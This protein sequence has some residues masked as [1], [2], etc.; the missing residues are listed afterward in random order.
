[1]GGVVRRL[2]SRYCWFGRGQDRAPNGFKGP[3]QDCMPVIQLVRVTG[4]VIA[5]SLVVG[6]APSIAR[7]QRPA[8]GPSIDTLLATAGPGWT[9]GTSEHFRVYV[10]R[11]AFSSRY[12]IEMLDSLERAWTSA[13]DLIASPV[14]NASPVTVLVTASRTRFARLLPPTAKGVTTSLPAVGDLVVLVHN[15]SVRP[16]ARHEVMHVVARRAWG[17]GS[18]F[19]GWVN[20]GLATYADGHCQGSTIMAVGRDILRQWPEVTVAEVADPSAALFSTN[21]ARA[22]VLSAT[23]VAY[24]WETAGRDAVRALWQAKDPRAVLGILTTGTGGD[25]PTPRWREWINQRAGSQIGL[26]SVA[27]QR[28]DC[29]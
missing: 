25:D 21:R 26:D 4:A 29:G 16:Y 9:N 14:T 24:V 27:F 2:R 8:P 15:D 6:G 22:Y 13:A 12:L 10:E 5:A 19:T 17:H 1:V 7:A 20:E 3:A 28:D 11:S 18:P 23:L